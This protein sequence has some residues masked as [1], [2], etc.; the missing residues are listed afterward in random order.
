MSGAPPLTLALRQV[1]LDTLTSPLVT[2]EALQAQINLHAQWVHS[3]VPL[4]ILTT[5]TYED[6]DLDG[7]NPWYGVFLSPPTKHNFLLLISHAL[8]LLITIAITITLTHLFTA[9]ATDKH[10]TTPTFPDHLTTHLF[11]KERRH[12][13]TRKSRTKSGRKRPNLKS[14]LFNSNN[15]MLLLSPPTNTHEARRKPRRNRDGTRAILRLARL[16]SEIHLD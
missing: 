3:A 13:V 10:P 15:N 9:H 4:G 11:V 2:P 8:M 14:N 1:S 7:L 12:F 5:A 6:I 16:I